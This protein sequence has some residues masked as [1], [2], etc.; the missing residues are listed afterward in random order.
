MNNICLLVGES[1]SGKTTIA[2]ILEN[3]YDYK[4]LMSYTTRPP[5]CDGEVGHV[6]VSDEEFDKLTDMVGYT[7]FNGYRYCATAQQVEENDIYVIDPAGVDYFKHAYRGDKNV[8]VIYISVDRGERFVRMINR[9]DPAEKVYE[10]LLNDDE[11]FA[12][13]EADYTIY[14]DSDPY[15]CADMIDMLLH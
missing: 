2:S 8:V 15:E 5:R 11:A 12:N 6:F 13:V 14:N 1:G 3:D 10:R 9:G 7:E 4:Q